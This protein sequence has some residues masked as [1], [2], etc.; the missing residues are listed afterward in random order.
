MKVFLI[1]KWNP[2]AAI[3]K[4]P[5]NKDETITNE[6]NHIP[7]KSNVANAILETPTKFLVKSFN[8]NNSNSAKTLWNLKVH[9][10]A[11]DMATVI[12]ASINKFSILLLILI[13]IYWNVQSLN[14]I[15]YVMVNTMNWFF[16]SQLVQYQ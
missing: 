13:V 14:L 16:C 8:P 4:N 10:N 15:T 9:T 1:L 12:W 7:T 3:I 2:W 5:I 6:G 11:T